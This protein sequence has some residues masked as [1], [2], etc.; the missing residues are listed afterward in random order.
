MPIPKSDEQRTQVRVINDLALE[1]MKGRAEAAEMADKAVA[2]INLLLPNIE[3]E[4]G[5]DQTTRPWETP[6]DE[7]TGQL[8]SRA[9]T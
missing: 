5:E 3:Q 1:A 7:D 8:T 6:N 9:R 2:S 4:E